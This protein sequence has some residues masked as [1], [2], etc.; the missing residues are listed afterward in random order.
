MTDT[1]TSQNTDLSSWD[2]LYIRQILTEQ[3]G[4][5]YENKYLYS[6]LYSIS[7]AGGLVTRLQ[8]ILYRLQLKYSVIRGLDAICIE[9][10]VL[11]IQRTCV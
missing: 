9:D 6:R 7:A 5:D 11:Q 3:Y 2:T 10:A 4:A 8:S 1:M